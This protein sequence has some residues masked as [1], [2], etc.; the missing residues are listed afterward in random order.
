[1]RSS[2]KGTLALLLAASVG[3]H[4]PSRPAE[5]Q[6]PPAPPD[7][8][9]PAPPP[10]PPP[11][12]ENAKPLS[13]SLR[14][15]A[16][17]EYEAGRILYGDKDYA[18]A[19]VKFEK[20]HELSGDPR[21]LWNVAVCEK[22]MRRYSRMLRTIR[23]YQTEATPILTPEER[24]Q[25]V[26]II[27]T[28][29]T[30]VSVLKLTASE[31]GADVYVDDE[32]LGTTPLGTSPT[33]E[34]IM[35]DVG[36]RR[37][38][39]V[40]PGFKDVTMTTDVVG[41]GE[42]RLDFALEKEIHRGRLEVKAAGK[43]DIISLDGKAVG[44]ETWEGSVPSGGHT[45]KVSA[46]GMAAYQSEVVIQDDKLRR[47]DVQLFPQARTD[48]TRT[49]LWIV[50]GAALA[51]GTAVGGFFLFKP[52]TTA[53]VTGTL[54]PGSTQLFFDSHGISFGGGRR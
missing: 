42:L 21:L 23:R 54:A 36:K 17:A 44:R 22:N 12:P 38:R 50:G 35:V 43:E 19:I 9:P 5:A 47:V 20:T 39:L 40:K 25:A 24:A 7:V 4:L 15:L 2:T 30:F 53:P 18:N 1:M 45:L 27:K 3:V 14:G 10:P 33:S 29:E 31:A 8:A 34:P 28:V 52:R 51:A 41:G 32:K 13:E 46:P 49:V 11:T 26:E 48:T 16:K 37:I 6:L